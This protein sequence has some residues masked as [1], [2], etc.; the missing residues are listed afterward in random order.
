MMVN[1]KRRRGK[2]EPGM[3]W[4]ARNKLRAGF[5][6]LLL[7]LVIAFPGVREIKNTEDFIEQKPNHAWLAADGAMEPHIN[8]LGMIWGIGETSANFDELPKR[9]GLSASTEAYR[10]TC[11]TR[12]A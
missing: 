2:R 11:T 6:L 10:A 1:T 7:L 4:I 3:T 5:G 12:Q 8:H 9:K